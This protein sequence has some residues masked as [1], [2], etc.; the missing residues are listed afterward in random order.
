MIIGGEI[1]GVG[2]ESVVLNPLIFQVYLSLCL[3][4]KTEASKSMSE[5][6]PPD[7]LDGYWHLSL[8]PELPYFDRASY[9]PL[10]M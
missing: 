7:P 8:K 3:Y 4:N 2:K 5:G 1:R 6:L 10:S 9:L